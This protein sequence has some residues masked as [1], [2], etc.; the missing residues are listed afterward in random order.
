M[1]SKTL[2][3]AL[4]TAVREVIKEELTEILREGLQST[5]NEIK[6]T[7]HSGKQNITQSSVTKAPA[8]PKNKVQFNENKWAS[9]LNET[10]PISDHQTSGISSFAELMNESFDAPS[11][12]ET[13]FNMTSRNAQGF[14]MQRQM[15]SSAPAAAAPKTM[16]DPETGKLMEV[17]PIVAKAMTRDYSTLMKAINKKKGFN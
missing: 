5:I 13:A 10:P 14:G 3:K 11:D 7:S 17:D 4:K 2:I 6:S 16:Q 8:T 12:Y 15:M 1:D 9:I